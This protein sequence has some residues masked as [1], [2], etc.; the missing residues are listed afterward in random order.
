M[1]VFNASRQEPGD[2]QAAINALE[3]ILLQ[4]GPR[5]PR[6]KAFEVKRIIER[7]MVEMRSRHT[8][9]A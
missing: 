2:F 7:L 3:K 9:H 8:V 1:E 6:A 4:Y 5:I